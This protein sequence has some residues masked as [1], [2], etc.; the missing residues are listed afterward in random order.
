MATY[1]IKK[2][3]KITRQAGDDSEVS[4][5]LP[6]VFPAEETE[7]RFGIFYNQSTNREPLIIL[8]T[9]DAQIEEQKVTFLLEKE[10]TINKKGP[11]LWELEVTHEGRTHTIG[12]GEFELIKKLMP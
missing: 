3:K 1:L 10:I 11:L 6:E 5:I 9:E 12:R 8:N 4:F 7:V 2:E